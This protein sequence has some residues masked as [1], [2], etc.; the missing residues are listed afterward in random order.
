MNEGLPLGMGEWTE[1]ESDSDSKTAE[2]AEGPLAEVH[3]HSLA[4]ENVGLSK[5]KRKLTLKE[6]C[7]IPNRIMAIFQSSIRW[8]A[9]RFNT[10]D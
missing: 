4:P 9:P 5:K 8:G 10:L 2:A 6:S 3:R 7:C 1:S